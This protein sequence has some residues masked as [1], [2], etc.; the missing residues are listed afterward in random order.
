MSITLTAESD[1]TWSF[2]ANQ[3]PDVWDEA[4]TFSITGRISPERVTGNS[5]THWDDGTITMATMN[6]TY[7]RQ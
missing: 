7:Q 2:T 1:G 4:E 6:L 3:I 5:M